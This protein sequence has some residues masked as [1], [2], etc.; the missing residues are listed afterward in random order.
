[1][2]NIVPLDRYYY[3]CM[4]LDEELYK[5]EWIIDAADDA[6]ML[7]LIEQNGGKHLETLSKDKITKLL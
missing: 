3:H 5:E 2:G 6:E 7:T 4:V 1:M